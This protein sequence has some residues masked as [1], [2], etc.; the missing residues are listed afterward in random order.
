MVFDNKDLRKLILTHYVR[1]KYNTEVYNG[2][3]KLFQE[4]L[5]KRWYH[6]CSC[7]L[8]KNNREYHYANYGELL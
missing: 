3:Q 5:I 7:E 1:M 8:C 2:I 6:Y 4:S